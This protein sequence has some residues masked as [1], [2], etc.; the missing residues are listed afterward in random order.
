MRSKGFERDQLDVSIFLL[1]SVRLY[2]VGGHAR[3][4]GTTRWD[5]YMELEITLPSKTYW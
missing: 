5:R 2:S 1:P 3:G 4:D